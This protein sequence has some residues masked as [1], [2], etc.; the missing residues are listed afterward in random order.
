VSQFQTATTAK[1]STANFRSVRCA[2]KEFMK[3]KTKFHLLA[4]IIAITLGLLFYLFVDL[5][6]ARSDEP[7]MEG[8]ASTKDAVIHLDSEGDRV[9]AVTLHYEW[10][11]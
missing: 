8:D 6:Q 5:N 9:T 7:I 3:S 2:V 11:D 1:T 10:E 4:A